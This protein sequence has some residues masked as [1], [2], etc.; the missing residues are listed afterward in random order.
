MGFFDIF[1]D[2]DSKPEVIEAQLN[3]TVSGRVQGV[4]FRWWTAGEAKHLKLVGYAKNLDNGD[5][6]IVAQGSQE[7][8]EKLLAILTSGNTAGHVEHVDAEITQPTGS[9]KGF[10]TY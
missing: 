6:K 2:A 5:V 1:S 7:S 8:C 9:Y 4:G 3:A 10:G